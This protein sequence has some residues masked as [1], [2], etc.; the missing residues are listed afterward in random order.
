[1]SACLTAAAVYLLAGLLQGLAGF[2]ASLLA[3]P[4][5]LFV[6]DVKTAVPLCILNGLVL[7]AFMGFQLRGHVQLARLVPLLLGLPLGILA[8]VYF[9]A[10]VDGAVVMFLLGV[11]ITAYAL[12]TLLASPEPRPL[13]P[14]WGV[15]AGFLS[16]AIS[17]GFSGGGPPTIIYSQLAGW[18]RDQ[19]KATLAVF[20]IVVTVF[21]STGHALAGLVTPQ[22]LLLTVCSA[23]C[24]V[25]GAVLGMLWS[26]RVEEA[27]FRRGV[28]VLL[29]VLGLATSLR[30]L[31]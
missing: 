20:F 31:L 16:G 14:G 29:A 28:L 11:L 19:F 1:M 21:S 27:A 26:R 8:G 4:V 13:K 17:A 7:T 15:L 22:V 24:V 2:G 9:L 23:P 30:A 3:M 18:K 5:L 10:H 25:V 12:Y 6:I